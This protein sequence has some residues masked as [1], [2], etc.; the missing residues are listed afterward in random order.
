LSMVLV[1]ETAWLS[2]GLA[3][4]HASRAPSLAR[5]ASEEQARFSDGRAS[6]II[7]PPLSTVSP[8]RPPPRIRSVELPGY[9]PSSPLLL[10][11][12]KTR[13]RSFDGEMKA[14]ES[15]QRDKYIFKACSLA[16]FAGSSGR[17]NGFP[18]LSFSTGQVL[19]PMVLEMTGRTLM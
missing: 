8:G 17:A 10:R 2:V 12:Q 7:S 15:P 19:V 14:P 1:F 9:Y 5:L 11:D 13:L 16:S 3:I 4:R 18:F 6:G